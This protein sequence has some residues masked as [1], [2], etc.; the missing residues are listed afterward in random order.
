MEFVE[1]IDLV[2][3]TTEILDCM[4]NMLEEQGIQPSQF[5][6]CIIFMSMCTDSV[7]WKQNNRN[8]CCDNATRAAQHAQNFKPGHWSSLGPG[9]E[10][11]W[12]RSLINKLTGK[13]N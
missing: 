5:Q 3:T 7:Y 2:K 10:D 13:W 12:Y 4:K 9:D 1:Q 11:K 6:D 8:D